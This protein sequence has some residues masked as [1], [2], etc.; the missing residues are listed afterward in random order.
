V[1]IITNP[2]QR[3]NRD[4]LQFVKTSKARHKIRQWLKAVE[5]EQSVGLGKELLD[6]ELRK[7]GASLQ[8]LLKDGDDL[9]KVAQDL[10]FHRVDDLLEAIGHGKLSPGQ[11][12]GRIQRLLFPVTGRADS[13]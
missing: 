10:S 8:K 2:N 1:E 11:V 5:R 3:P 13:R 12:G 9:K 7:S 4:W 6:R